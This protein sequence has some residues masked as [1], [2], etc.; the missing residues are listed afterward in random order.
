[1]LFL[2]GVGACGLATMLVLVA[3]YGTHGRLV[4]IALAFFVPRTVVIGTGLVFVHV[5]PGFLRGAFLV[6]FIF[7]VVLG[8]R[9]NRCRQG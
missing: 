2:L 8:E 5:G 7:V 6:G 1:M 3:A 4:L 9:W